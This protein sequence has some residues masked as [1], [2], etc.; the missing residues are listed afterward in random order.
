MGK[1]GKK[2][3]GKRG[4]WGDPFPSILL[5]SS[6]VHGFFVR[7]HPERWLSGWSAQR[8]AISIQLKKLF[9]HLSL[10]AEN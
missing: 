7:F 3:G 2:G 8:I 1:K 5:P 6:R 9:I 10:I 4:K